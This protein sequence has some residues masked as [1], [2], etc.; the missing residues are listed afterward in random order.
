MFRARVF[1]IRAAIFTTFL[2]SSLYPNLVQAGVFQDTTELFDVPYVRTNG[3]GMEVYQPQTGFGYTGKV[4][5]SA[6]LRDSRPIP[7]NFPAGSMNFSNGSPAST[8]S[9]TQTIELQKLDTPNPQSGSWWSNLKTTTENVWYYRTPFYDPFVTGSHENVPAELLNYQKPI[10]PPPGDLGIQVTNNI[11]N[12]NNKSA[13][14]TAT[15]FTFSGQANSTTYSND[16]L[17]F[18]WDFTSD[19]MPDTYFSATPRVTFQYP[20]V[21]DYTVT[22]QV[23]DPAGNIVSKS[24][25]ITI[26]QNTPPRAHFV[27]SAETVFEGQILNFDTG[28]S[29]D[30]QYPRNN[31]NYRFDWNGDGH[32]DTPWSTKTS[33]N[34][35]FDQVGTFRVKMQAADPEGLIDDTYFDITVRMDLPPKADFQVESLRKGIYYFNANQS[36]DDATKLLKYRWDSNYT[37]K[38]DILFDTDFSYF[39]IYTINYQLSGNKTVRLQVMDEKGQIDESM[40][41]F[42]VE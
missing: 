21:G 41:T 15:V 10:I 42:F 4:G 16:S 27:V 8:P 6:V 40:A 13:G 5:Q 25:K 24:T 29:S 22:M 39:S 11:S 23:L 18:R 20:E 35:R 38:D 1:T 37:G 7:G 36:N 30:D 12:S 32:Y 3:N 31:L 17:R 9:P 28:L 26:V 19:G 14:T 2:A 34:H 33:W